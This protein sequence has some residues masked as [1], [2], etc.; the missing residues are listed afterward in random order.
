MST[1]ANVPRHTQ[2]V[3]RRHILAG[4]AAAGLAGLPGIFDWANAQEDEGPPRLRILG[5]SQHVDPQITARFRERTGAVIDVT[6]IGALEDVAVFLRAGGVGYF[7]LV[8]PTLGLLRP[9]AEAEL[10]SALDDAALPNLDGLLP[11]FQ[12]MDLTLQGDVRVGVPLLW[13]S[14]PLAYAPDAIENPP[15]TWLDLINPM[16]AGKVVMADD[17]LGHFWIW[18]RALGAPD[19]TRVTR[20]QLSQTATLL[21]DIKTNLAVRFES[22]VLGALRS[23]AEGRGALSTVGWQSAPLVPAADQHPLATRHPAPGDA[24]FCD[25]LAVVRDAPQRELAHAFIDDMI[26][27]ETQARLISRLRWGTVAAGAVDQL[28]LEVRDLYDY[29]NLDGILSISPL[30]GYPPLS[31]D[32]ND[33]AT[34]VDWVAAWDRIR[35]AEIERR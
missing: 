26:S 23:V 35:S 31:D 1:Q 5:W 30:Y 22:T 15:D 17:L 18:N 34:Y 32:G 10:T 6:P 11:P 28:D 25:C 9:L 14:L 13:G 33:T 16:Y 19:P 12:R 21:M 4:G 27:A 24:S 7:D 20:G 2:R 29:A 3:T 8:I